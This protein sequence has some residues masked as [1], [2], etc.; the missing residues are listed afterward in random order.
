MNQRL[1]WNFEISNHPQLNFND[2]SSEEDKEMKWEARFFWSTDKIITL[3][4]LD[5]Q[6]INLENY[7]IKHRKD[8]YLLL[9]QSHY[10]VKE[11]RNKIFY[12]PR[13][14]LIEGIPGYGKK[15]ELTADNSEDSLPGTEGISALTLLNEL[16]QVANKVSVDKIALVYRLPTS[17]TL[18][19]ELSR[20]EV[21]HTIYFSAC[22][23]GRSQ[24]LVRD[25][26]KHLLVEPIFCDYVSFLQQALRHD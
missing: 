26:A 16:E 10:N 8:Q 12:K 22:I 14:N 5:N 3:R 11:R 13:L 17:P 18:K 24:K 1:V 25:F 15:I 7:D 20:L 2:F 19:L 4:G 21:E 6:F 23:E 9:P